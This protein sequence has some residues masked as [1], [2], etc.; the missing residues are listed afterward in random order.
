[1]AIWCK[2]EK[3][4]GLYAKEGRPWEKAFRPKTE[5]K[6]RKT[7][8][9]GIEKGRRQRLNEREREKNERGANCPGTRKENW[10]VGSVGTQ[11]CAHRNSGGGA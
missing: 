11:R 6:T 7:L 10:E 1:L 3:K 5:K 4:E 2:T 9:Q 8:Y